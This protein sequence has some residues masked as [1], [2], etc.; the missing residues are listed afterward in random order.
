MPVVGGRPDAEEQEVRASEALGEPVR[1]RRDSEEVTSPRAEKKA[2]AKPQSRKRFG[3]SLD[4]LYHELEGTEASAVSAGASGSLSAGLGKPRTNFGPELT[5]E[6]M[7]EREKSIF[8]GIGDDA[9]EASDEQR[10]TPQVSEN[11]AVAQLTYILWDWWTL[12]KKL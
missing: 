10:M 4:D 8:K 5:D 11:A 9:M 12:R 2:K 7:E 1:E 3:E 6:Q